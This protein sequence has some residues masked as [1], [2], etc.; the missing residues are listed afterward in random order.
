MSRTSKEGNLK[1]EV[2]TGEWTKEAILGLKIGKIGVGDTSMIVYLTGP[3][4][5]RVKIYGVPGPG[6]STGGRRFFFRKKIGGR[7]LVH[8]PLNSYSVFQ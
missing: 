1:C 6:P 8:K 4:K 5:G 2:Q 7:T 3:S